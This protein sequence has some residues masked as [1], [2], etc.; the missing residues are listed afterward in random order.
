[1]TR[2]IGIIGTL[3]L[4]GSLMLAGGIAFAAEGAAFE[5]TV[6]NVTRGQTF[7]PILLASHKAGVR[8]FTP[9]QPAS[10]EL[11]ILAES[12]NVAPLADL[13]VSLPEVFEVTD[14]GTTLGPGQTVTVTVNTRGAF[15]HIS[16]AAMLIPTNDGFFALNGVPG[17]TK[18]EQ[19]TMFISPAYDAGSEFND[20]DCA[21]I[22]GPPDVCSGEGV[23]DPASD[24]E[25]FVHIHAG[26]H[27]ITTQLEPAT[28][29]W[30]NPV[31][32]IR[33]KRVVGDH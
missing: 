30:R 13:L 20:E 3:L 6:T 17:P 10:E 27:G 14:T 19:M 26:I 2:R 4:L 18:P 9:G 5:V 1:M 29:D 22:P 21:N 23:S 16:V 15:D 25:G 33:V 28:Y 12:G 32:S 7:T 31:A 24:D 8:L 11:A